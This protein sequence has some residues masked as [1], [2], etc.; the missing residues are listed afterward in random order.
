MLWSTALCSAVC[1]PM[2]YNANAVGATADAG[3][4]IH[5]GGGGGGADVS[6]VYTGCIRV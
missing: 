1:R 3:A 6:I 5:D 4:D 2:R